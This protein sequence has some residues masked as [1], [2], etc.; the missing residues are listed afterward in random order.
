MENKKSLKKQNEG[1]KSR[2][3]RDVSA[4]C[5]DGLAAS[6]QRIAHI[7]YMAWDPGTKKSACS[8]EVCSILGL[9]QDE[10]TLTL[11]ALLA[12]IHQDDREKVSEGARGEH[13]R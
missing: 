9:A 4:E 3:A 13:R 6:I 1:E 5:D 11:D 12:L 2:Q 7:G 10:K 8:E